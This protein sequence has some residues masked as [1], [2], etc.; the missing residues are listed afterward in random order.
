[1]L[2]GGNEEFYGEVIQLLRDHGVPEKL[3]RLEEVA[4]VFRKQQEDF[5]LQRDADK[6]TPEDLYFFYPAEESEEFE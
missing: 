6:I 1:M 5:L 2:I 3:E 4:I